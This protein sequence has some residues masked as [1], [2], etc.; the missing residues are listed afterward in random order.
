MDVAFVLLFGALGLPVL[1][2][3]SA[4]WRGYVLSVLWGWFVVPAFGLPA[5]S[6]P[7]AIG[8]S[9][10]VSFLTMHK[11]GNEAEK[12]RELSEAFIHSVVVAALVP[13]FVLFAGWVVTKFL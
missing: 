10:I 5:L 4:L 3:L 8:L 6:V 1:I 13:A 2:A 7:L 9:L 12:D 11:T